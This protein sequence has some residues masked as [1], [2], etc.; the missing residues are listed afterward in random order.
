M[1]GRGPLRRYDGTERDCYIDAA[2][3]ERVIVVTDRISAFDVVLGTIPSKG[4]VLNQLARY[5]FDETAHRAQK[6]WIGDRIAV[7]DLILNA[8]PIKVGATR[9]PHQSDDQH[10]PTNS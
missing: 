1:A 10:P 3:G 4:L 7:F 2:A 6:L 9:R 5:W 8:A